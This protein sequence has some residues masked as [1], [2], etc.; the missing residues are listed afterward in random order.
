MS[1]KPF[2]IAVVAGEASSDMIGAS[3]ISDLLQLNPTL[4]IIAVGGQKMSATGV[5]IIQDNEI[6]SIMGCIMV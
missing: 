2:K 1:H 6:F 5:K 3:L 4:E